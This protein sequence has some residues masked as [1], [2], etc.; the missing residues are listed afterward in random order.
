M[1]RRGAPLPPRPAAPAA[2]LLKSD[3]VPVGMMRL[4]GIVKTSNGFAVASV[5]LSAAEWA[6][7][8][9]KKLGK[10]QAF[11][12]FVAREHREVVVRLGQIA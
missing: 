3:S 9:S 4:S 12:E 7:L 8:A 10:S 2:P 11:K 1:S 5:E 6:A